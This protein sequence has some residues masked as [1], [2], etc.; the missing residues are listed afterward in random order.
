VAAESEL[1]KELTKRAKLDDPEARALKLSFDNLK[2]RLVKHHYPWVISNCQW[3]TDHGETHVAAVMNSASEL[4]KEKLGGRKRDSLTTLDIYLIL[5]AILWHDVG[6]VISRARHAE[7]VYDMTWGVVDFFPNPTVQGLV[8]QIANAHKGHKGLDNLPTDDLCTVD[9][10]AQHVNTA[11]LA[12]VVR[13][14][15]EI[16]ENHTRVSLPI[17]PQVPEDQK[18][19]W[20]YAASIGSSVALPD[21]GRVIVD[22]RF[23]AD[24]VTQCWPD[25]DFPALWPEGG[26][27]LPLLTY[28]LGRLEKINNEREYCFQYFSSV[29]PIRDV[30]ARFCITRA[31]K[32]LP[33]YENASILLRGGGVAS[34]EYPQIKIIQDFLREHPQWK[35]ESIEGVLKS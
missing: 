20:L 22:Y 27:K 14:A 29:A 3:F 7:L 12:A 24:Y 23:D 32:K 26:N 30:E 5:T 10:P 6:M 16:S 18:I 13:F 2:A 25:K 1:E 35:V 31:G 28:A 15:D 19:F 8:A 33:G 34:K 9:G 11:L 21:R 4:V 17:L